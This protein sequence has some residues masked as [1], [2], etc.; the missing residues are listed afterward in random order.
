MLAKNLRLSCFEFYFARDSFN[1][2]F[3]F[4]FVFF[5]HSFAFGI[6]ISDV[7]GYLYMALMG[8]IDSVSDADH[9]FC[10]R[11]YRCHLKFTMP[12]IQYAM[13]KGSLECSV[14]VVF[15]LFFSVFCLLRAEKQNIF[16]CKN[17]DEKMNGVCMFESCALVD[18]SRSNNICRC[19]KW[20]LLFTFISS[21]SLFVLPH[22]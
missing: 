17:C 5:I 4:F 8:S 2:F 13:L 18:T 19:G 16:R 21:S 15:P 14:V 12:T 7:D 10:G 11:I 3:F 6:D 22:F 1:C 9:L 20:N